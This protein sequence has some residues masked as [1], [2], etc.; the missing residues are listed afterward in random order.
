[1][2]VP[3]HSCNRVRHQDVLAESLGTQLPAC[4]CC[5]QYMKPQ[6]PRRLGAAMT[7]VHL[8]YNDVMHADSAGVLLREP[9]LPRERQREMTRAR[10]SCINSSLFRVSP[11]RIHWG[12]YIQQRWVATLQQGS[13]LQDYFLQLRPTRS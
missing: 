8:I 10:C 2:I 6:Q 5:R 1:M 11:G 12:I 3:Q 9:P 13:D 4:R 7:H